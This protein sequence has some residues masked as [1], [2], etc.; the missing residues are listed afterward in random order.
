MSNLSD[1]SDMNIIKGA[2]EETIYKIGYYITLIWNP[3]LSFVGLVGNVLATLA[4]FQKHNR[5]ISSCIYM[6]ILGLLD[7][8]TNVIHLL[9]Y[10]LGKGLLTFMY[11]ES[12]HHILCRIVWYL[13]S[14]VVLA[15]S[16]VVVAMTVDRF[17][18]VRW[19]LKTLHFC[20]PRRA[21][22][23]CTF[24]ICLAFSC[25]VPYIWLIT[26]VGKLNCVAFGQSDN[27]WITL[28]Y[29]INTALSCYIPFVILLTLNILIIKAIR[30]TQRNK[31]ISEGSIH[32]FTSNGT[33]SS[34]KYS[35]A[36][37][38]TNGISMT[39]K[40]NNKRSNIKTSQVG[41]SVTVMLLLVSFAFILL[42]APIY[43]FY[44]VYMIKSKYSSSYAYAE[45]YFSAVFTSSIYQF[46]SAINFY[47]YCFSGTKFRSDLKLLFA[48]CKCNAKKS[49]VQETSDDVSSVCRQSVQ[50][51]VA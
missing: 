38:A 5:K 14:G 15:S 45:Y 24:V 8:L 41:N 31:Y 17:L 18:A 47:L 28:Y 33:G 51:T 32:Q 10:F 16:F 39:V 3:T 6:G 37:E 20:T 13:G 36:S 48:K 40:R 46:N 1:V 35:T 43:I 2:M 21:K 26:A 30:L 25:K 7:L 9:W 49:D 12:M 19:P 44:I 42:T 23:V 34:T 22:L 4:L 29:W 11:S 27:V 50:T